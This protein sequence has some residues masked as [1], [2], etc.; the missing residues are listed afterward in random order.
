MPLSPTGTIN[1]EALMELFLALLN[2]SVALSIMVIWCL[3]IVFTTLTPPQIF[4]SCIL[5][6]YQSSHVQFLL[7][8]LSSHDPVSSEHLVQYT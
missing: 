7:F 5:S 2:V 6:T 1:K 4:E 8:Q 3:I